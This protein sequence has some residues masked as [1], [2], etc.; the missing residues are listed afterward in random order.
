MHEKRKKKRLKTS[1]GEKDVQM[2]VKE[3]D[4]GEEINP[5]D[6]DNQRSKNIEVSAN[7]LSPEAI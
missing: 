7:Q 6:A 1:D 2:M 4:E 3:E 5:E